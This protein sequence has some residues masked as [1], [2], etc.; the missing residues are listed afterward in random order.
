MFARFIIILVSSLT[1][2][3]CIWFAPDAFRAVLRA[4]TSLSEAAM[5][6]FNIQGH[7]ALLF[8]FGNVGLTLALAAL[9]FMVGALLRVL[10]GHYFSWWR[11]TTATTLPLLAHVL[12]W[13]LAL[14]WPSALA[15][16]LRWSEW[17][18]TQLGPVW[19]A[20]ASALGARDLID[21]FLLAMVILIVWRGL[22]FVLRRL[23]GRRRPVAVPPPPSSS[24]RPQPT[25]PGPTRRSTMLKSLKKTSGWLWRKAKSVAVWTKK[26]LVAKLQPDEDFHGWRFNPVEWNLLFRPVA[27][28]AAA[29][30]VT[31]ALWAVI[32]A[33]TWL[34]GGQQRLPTWFWGLIPLAV[35]I[36]SFVVEPTPEAESV[37]ETK[38]LAMVTW[39]GMPLPIYRVTGTYA[40]LGTVLGFGRTRKTT[41]EFTDE[42]GFIKA[43]PVPFKVWNRADSENPD[44]V[45]KAPAKNRAEIEST[46]TLIL[47][48]EDPRKLLDSDDPEL[49]IGDRARQEYRE[50]VARFVDTDIPSLG[51]A[52]ETLLK[53]G[54]LL[55]AFISHSTGGYKAGAMVRDHGDDPVFQVFDHKP[56][57]DEIATFTARI[58]NEAQPAMRTL[59]SKV[60]ES[61]GME[62]EVN[63]VHIERPVTEV[64]DSVGLRL[65]RVTMGDIVLSD[66]VTEAANAASSEAD[67]R[68]A[69]LASADTIKAARKALLPDADEVNNPGWELAQVIAAAQDNGNGAIKIIMVPGGDGLTRAM[70]AGGGQIGGNS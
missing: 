62:V 59:V 49:D 27:S 67:Q 29:L 10:F 43:G 55:T 36:V 46:L 51:E 21:T 17:A 68:A 18:L 70:V 69:Q 11:V 13:M 53:G 28:I 65:K 5:S 60:S 2:A 22:H 52:I 64:T 63:R 9:T 32:T 40:W 42:K 35:G 4:G 16:L 37:P 56:T 14:W 3:F 25:K 24:P 7:L 45:I 58:L 41:P 30:L 31:L 38:Y 8:E 19:Y 66:A 26:V 34:L 33:L 6:Q 23:F 1:A 57:E 50:L 44:A 48:A 20:R 47:E 39:L 61:G 15:A 12:K 54:Y